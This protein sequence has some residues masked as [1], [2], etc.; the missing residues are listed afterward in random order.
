MI[1]YTIHVYNRIINY[2]QFNFI[3]LLM[4]YWW[5]QNYVI[6]DKTETKYITRNA[7]HIA[8]RT[9]SRR[10]SFLEKSEL[11]NLKLV[12]VSISTIPYQDMVNQSNNISQSRI[13]FINPLKWFPS[14]E[15]RHVCKKYSYHVLVTSQSMST[16]AAIEFQC[17]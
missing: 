16:S 14:N 12:Q 11:W 8:G 9:Q 5:T 6:L 17:F 4:W 15:L 3:T 2:A 7:N 13:L 1:Y 10:R